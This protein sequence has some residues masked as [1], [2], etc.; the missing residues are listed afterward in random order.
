MSEALERIV[1]VYERPK[2]RRALENLRDHR[3]KLLV[4]LAK[5]AGS[6]D[7]KLP[8]G[9]I[10]DELALIEAALERLASSD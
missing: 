8:A 4:D 7:V 5:H 9:Q 3:Q 10:K 6:F 1:S 2:N